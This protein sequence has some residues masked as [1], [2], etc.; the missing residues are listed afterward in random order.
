MAD[1][2]SSTLTEDEVEEM[3][4]GYVH[5]EK[6]LEPGESGSVSLDAS[7]AS[8]FVAAGK[9]YYDESLA[10][11]NDGIWVKAVYTSG[12][13]EEYMTYVIEGENKSGALN[14]TFGLNGLAL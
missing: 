9:L 13:T 8:P 2:G 10:A 1:I 4:Y 6:Q 3:G 7:V 12:S 11:D 5:A 14:R